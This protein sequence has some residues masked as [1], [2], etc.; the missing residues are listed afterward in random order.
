MSDSTQPIRVLVPF[1]GDWEV[2]ALE[3]LERAGHIELHREG[4]DCRRFPS[5]L[6]LAWFEVHRFVDRLCRKYRG[7]IDSVWSC[8][9]Q[10]GCLISAVVAERL[11]LPGTR[12]ATVV[13]AQHKL[14][15]RQLLAEHLPAASVA[16]AA[17]PFRLGDRRLADPALVSAA[18]A[19]QGLEWP[20]FAKPLKATFSVLAREV[21]NAEE[22]VLH[23]RLPAFDRFV[24]RRM[25]RPFESLARQY[26]DLPA[27]ADCALL[28]EP[29]RGHQVNVDGFAMRGEFH[30]LG[31]VDEW[32]YANEA[33]GARH[34]AGFT[35]PSRLSADVRARTE[36][37]AL[38]AM[39][40]VGFDHGLFNVELFVCDDGSIRIIEINPRAAGQFA[41]FYR[42]VEGVSLE[43][44]GI[45][46]SAGRDPRDAPRWAARAN[47]AGSIVWR[48]FDGGCGVVPS[49][50]SRDWLAASHP[51]AQLWLQPTDR[52]SVEREYRWLGSHRYAVLNCA[53]GDYAA[54]QSVG[55]ECGRRLFGAPP[56]AP[57]I[58]RDPADSRRTQSSA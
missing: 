56:T 36:A 40:V 11:G 30:V 14:M 31:V 39:R 46:L 4:F 17:V 29:L 54:L 6:Q 32:M 38:A 49:P 24:L 2:G 33:G 42:D 13:R 27:P 9:E 35:Y 19:A 26:V 34:F 28:E 8:D 20:L 22:L 57:V 37:T 25:T 53:A 7:R 55:D 58:D 12:P 45:W 41:T 23:M 47:V 10:F 16:A 48:R 21:R 5:C 44:M 43:L 18:V 50:A 3:E 1:R 52:R 51:H 15:L